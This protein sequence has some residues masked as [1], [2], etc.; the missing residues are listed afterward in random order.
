MAQTLL[1]PP[2]Q[3]CLVECVGVR[4]VS[5]AARVY[6][7]GATVPTKLHVQDPS[8]ATDSRPLKPGCTCYTCTTHTRAYVY[9]LCNVHEMLAVTLLQA[10][11]LHTY[12][13]FFGAVREAVRSGRLAEYRAWFHATHGLVATPGEGAG[14]G[15][16]AGAGVAAA[17]AEGTQ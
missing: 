7:A 14:A 3:V 12:A 5:H 13:A 11:N 17:T 6:S 8:W 1:P 4:A 2:P 10:H 16:G 15:A 9:H